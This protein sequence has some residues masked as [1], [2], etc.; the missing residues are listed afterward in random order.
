M[1]PLTLAPVLLVQVSVARSDPLTPDVCL[2]PLRPEVR[3]QIRDPDE[4]RRSDTSHRFCQPVSV[5]SV[6]KS[7]ANPSG[8]TGPASLPNIDVRKSDPNSLDTA[9]NTLYAQNMRTFT[10]RPTACLPPGRTI[11]AS[12]APASPHRRIIFSI[13]F[14]PSCASRRLFRPLV[15]CFTGKSSPFCVR[16]A[17]KMVT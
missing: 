16:A 17:Q 9:T 6:S 7:V 12:P 10:Y 4:N 11:A 15:S 13:S 5:T 1:H 3:T 8:S 2:N 14:A